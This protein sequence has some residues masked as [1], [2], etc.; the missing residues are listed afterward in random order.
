[1]NMMISYQELVRTFPSLNAQF[2]TEEE[3]QE[4][5]PLLR[6]EVIFGMQDKARIKRRINYASLV[7]NGFYSFQKIK[8]LMKQGKEI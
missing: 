3:L 2:F 7:A 5:D 6:R 4:L 8:G 1:M